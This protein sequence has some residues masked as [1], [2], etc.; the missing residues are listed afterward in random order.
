MRRDSMNFLLFNVGCLLSG[1]ILTW[2][3]ADK[4]S[5]SVL[6]KVGVFTISSFC[7]WMAV[8]FVMLCI[9]AY[10]SSDRGKR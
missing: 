9:G 2:L 7:T 10:R 4:W 5:L 3:S 6:E 8:V 1:I